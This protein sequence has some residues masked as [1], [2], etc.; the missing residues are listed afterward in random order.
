MYVN[1]APFADP[2]LYSGLPLVTMYLINTV[3]IKLDRIYDEA[4]FP[5]HVILSHN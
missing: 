3:I 4:R 2:Y 1:S 5:T